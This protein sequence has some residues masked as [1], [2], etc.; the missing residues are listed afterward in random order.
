MEIERL[1]AI[2]P[3]VTYIGIADGAKDLWPC[4]LKYLQVDK[5]DVFHATEYFTK[6]SVV[7]KKG[8][9]VHKQWTDNACHDM[10]HKKR[11]SIYCQGTQKLGQRK[12][13]YRT[14]S[15]LKNYHLL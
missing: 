9:Q 14:G 3:A 4:L 12:C 13:E 7:L 10:K 8:E 11:C 15:G 5:L 2:L 1:K 6:G